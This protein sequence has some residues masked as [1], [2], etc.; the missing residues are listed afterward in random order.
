MRTPKDVSPDNCPM[1][2]MLTQYVPGESIA[3][4]CVESDGAVTTD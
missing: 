1:S 3:E 2:V 4:I